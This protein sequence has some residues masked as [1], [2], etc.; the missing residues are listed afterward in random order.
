MPSFIVKNGP[1][2]PPQKCGCFCCI[3]GLV[4]LNFFVFCP[5]FLLISC[6]FMLSWNPKTAHQVRLQA[7]IYISHV[8]CVSRLF[9]SKSCKT[10]EFVTRKNFGANFPPFSDLPPSL[11]ES[12]SGCRVRSIGNEECARTFFAQ[13]FWRPPGV[14]DIPA[15][16]PGHPRFLSS[17]P[18]KDKLSREGTK[19]SATT[20]SRGRPP[21]D[22]VVSGPK[23]LIFVLFF[24]WINARQ[25]RVNEGPQSINAQQKL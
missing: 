10:R 5:L 7:Y 25:Y 9:L 15:K 22:Q 21:P 16:F 20:P 23:K 24:A 8:F 14:R 17:K 6:C 2:K 4:F 19:F 12:I 11:S 18:K 3:F 13:T 1:E